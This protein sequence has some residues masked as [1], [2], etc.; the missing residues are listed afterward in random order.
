[1]FNVKPIVSEKETDCGATCLKMILDYYG[2]EVDLDTL[3][4]EC[5]TRIA[6]C[7]GLDL[8]RVANAHGL[9]LQGFG[10]K[11]ADGILYVDRPGIIWWKYNHWCVY[12]GLDKG[13]AVIINPD[14]GL[15]HMPKSTFASFYTNVA[16]FNGEPQD[17]E[18]PSQSTEERLN[19][20]EDEL[21]A[22][23]IVLG[24]E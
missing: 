2:I 1:M 14:R 13:Q 3:I 10:T 20:L 5:N 21:T 12:C 24:V 22:A 8:K 4:K 19:N 18:D 6:G 16:F 15:Y 7:T 9:E 17:I 11:D 23:K